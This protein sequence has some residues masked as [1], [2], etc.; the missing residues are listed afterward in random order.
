MGRT[1]RESVGGLTADA[2]LAH[3]EVKHGLA[4]D[5]A[6]VRPEQGGGGRHLGHG[7]L[8][9]E[10]LMEAGQ[11]IELVSTGEMRIKIHKSSKSDRKV[12]DSIMGGNIIKLKSLNQKIEIFLESLPR[13]LSTLAKGLAG[14]VEAGH[15]G[16]IVAMAQGRQRMSG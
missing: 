13:S 3:V 16:Y 12:K 1:G 9:G 8:G 5:T 14:H 10:D 15:E 4:E 2:A 11:L 7:Q 6:H